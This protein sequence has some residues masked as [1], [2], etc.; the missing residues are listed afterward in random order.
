MAAE[1]GV[2]NVNSEFRKTHDL[3]LKEAVARVD[4]AIE[5]Y[6]A[7][8]SSWP[9]SL[10]DM[11]GMLAGAL[12]V[13]HWVV[14]ESYDRARVNGVITPIYDTNRRGRARYFFSD[15]MVRAFGACCWAR[16]NN[17]PIPELKEK[18]GT[19]QFAQLI[20]LKTA[21]WSNQEIESG[22][23]SASSQAES[24]AIE[25]NENQRNGRGPSPVEIEPDDF[26]ELEL[27][28]KRKDL[29][30]LAIWDKD[31]LGKLQG[32]LPRLFES[33]DTRLV[34]AELVEAVMFIHFF[35]NKAE[36]RAGE[37]VKTFAFKGA[38]QSCLIY[39]EKYPE[40]KNLAQLFPVVYYNSAKI[41]GW[42][43]AANNN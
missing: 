38:L 33:I 8:R 7:T 42:D 9:C 1:R 30:K 22:D 21:S 5:K 16:E 14:Y 26:P 37:E 24:S 13:S 2:T 32:S 4:V 25:L 36:W 31:A 17:V 40:L 28:K 20:N 11:K 12:K 35:R 29:E 3:G 10:G 34:P 27:L 43:S 41:N 15:D 19:M 18:L 39:L 23:I 6:N